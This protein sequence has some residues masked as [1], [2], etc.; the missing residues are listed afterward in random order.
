M[1]WCLLEERLIFFNMGT[2]RSY[3]N[4]LGKIAEDEIE[5][6]V[7]SFLP[8]GKNISYLDCGC[9]DGIKTSKRAKVIGTKR[10]LGIEGQES[11][12]KKAQRLGIK[13]LV[14]NLNKK[15]PLQSGS[16]DCITATEVIEHL[17]DLDNFFSEAKRVLRKNGSIIISTE[18]LAGY[19]NIFALLLG[20]QPYTGP[21][22]SRVY[23]I[24]HRPYGKFYERKLP[25]D[26]H[27]N[28]MTAKALEQLV[29]VHG[30]KIEISCSAGFYPFPPPFFQL[31]AKLDKNHASYIVVK[32]I[33]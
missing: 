3:L 19:S 9:D 16:V 2:L 12:A 27:V 25:M 5:E 24:G 29:C 6:K 21:Y 13:I 8:C 28:V 20:N 30:F 4:Y 26:P 23:P 14:A 18:N 32:A 11:R 7:Y 22:L 31:F 17:I 15:W 10:I 33:K 1:E